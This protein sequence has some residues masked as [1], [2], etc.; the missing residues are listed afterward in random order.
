[1]KRITAIIIILI[2]FSGC[3]TLKVK[4]T[5]IIK[6]S[7]NEKTKITL[8]K[9][10]VGIAK[11]QNPCDEDGNLRPIFYESSSG[12]LKTTVKDE[13]GAILIAQEQKTDTIYKER[14][15]YKDKLIYKDKLVEVEV[16]P[17]WAWKSLIAN[18][19]LLLWILR[20][21]LLRLINPIK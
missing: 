7:I 19:I 8:I 3:R 1:M 11:L 6:D 9:S 4:D 5:S 10:S 12:G 18:I 2:M 15:V 14:L 16:T 13:N 20:K 21:P 17:K